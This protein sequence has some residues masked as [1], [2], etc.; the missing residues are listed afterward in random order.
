MG[1][2][3]HAI[4]TS[5][6]PASLIHLV[7]NLSRYLILHISKRKNQLKFFYL[8]I[9][10]TNYQQLCIGPASPEEILRW[11]ERRLLNGETV[12]GQVD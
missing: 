11:A 8:M 12:V 9:H 5:R 7:Y 2:V 1:L 6:W 4:L 3:V 10:R